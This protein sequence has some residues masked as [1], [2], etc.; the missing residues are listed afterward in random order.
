MLARKVYNNDDITFFSV[1]QRLQSPRVIVIA[2]LTASRIRL[3]H[4]FSHSGLANVDTRERMFYPL[5][6][7]TSQRKAKYVRSSELLVISRKIF[8]GIIHFKKK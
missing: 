5:I 2:A 3:Q 7:K 8:G 6:K 4:K 1:Y